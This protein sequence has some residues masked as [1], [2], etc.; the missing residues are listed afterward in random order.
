VPTLSCTHRHQRDLVSDRVSQR[1]ALK[2]AVDN[3]IASEVAPTLLLALDRLEQRLEVALAKPLRAVPLDQFVEHCRAILDWLGEDLQQVAILVPVGEDFQLLQFIE[4]HS[5]VAY[6]FAESL[7]V[8]VGR[9][10][11]LNAFGAHAT[12]RA[13]D[14]VGCQRDVLYSW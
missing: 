14:V 11:E 6:P 12:N 3:K 13:H 8:A 5:S 7:V 2:T 1:I 9:I 10:Q 4:R